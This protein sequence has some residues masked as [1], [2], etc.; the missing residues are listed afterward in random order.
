MQK[1]KEPR[2]NQLA[3]IEMKPSHPVTDATG[4]VRPQPT[5][6]DTTAGTIAKVHRVVP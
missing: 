1:Y 5:A 2:G 6:P 4:K 3:V